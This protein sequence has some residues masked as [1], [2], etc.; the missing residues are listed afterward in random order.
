MDIFQAIDVEDLD[1][2][3]QL[4]LRDA[5]MVNSIDPETDRTPLTIAARNNDVDIGLVLVNHGANVNKVDGNDSTPLMMA[6]SA[7]MTE[8][9]TFLLEQEDIKV[10][11]QGKDGMTA[12]LS[13]VLSRAVSIVDML[14]ESGADPNVSMNNGGTPLIYSIYSPA[15]VKLLLNKNADVNAQDKVGENAL[16][17]SVGLTL[18]ETFQLLL[19]NP[20]INVDITNNTG[21]TPLM[22]A[23]LVR[24]STPYYVNALLDAGADPLM[25]N[26]IGK[27]ALDLAKMASRGHDSSAKQKAL[28]HAMDY[29]I[30]RKDVAAR[31]LNEKLMIARRLRQGTTTTEES[32]LELP[33]RDL[34]EGLIRKAEYENLCMGLQNNLNKPGVIALARSLRIPTSNQTKAQLCQEIAKRL[35]I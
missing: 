17:R 35:I 27:T 26:N 22:T 8:F 21:D 29:W 20:N 23:A 3:N 1:R 7:G 18:P 32:R 31:E 4:L 34:T 16:R 5:T 14:L 24:L 13:A 19:N 33:S 15:I 25:K 2:V 11:L 9:V 6:A 30:I 12:L 10:N 28:M